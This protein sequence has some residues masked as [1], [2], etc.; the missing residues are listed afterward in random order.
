MKGRYTL[1]LLILNLAVA[2]V[3][4]YLHILKNNR[5]EE[6]AVESEIFSINLNDADYLKIE[7]RELNATRII[8]KRNGEWL[9]S[10]PMQWKANLH[11]VNRV[12]NQLRWLKPQ[13]SFS[14]EETRHHDQSLEDYGLAQPRLTVTIG[15]GTRRESLR[16]GSA[17]TVGDRIYALSPDDRQIYVLSHKIVEALLMQMDD[18]RS[19]DIL[20][21]PPTEVSALRIQNREDSN[22][23]SSTALIREGKQWNFETPIRARA[24]SELVEETLSRLSQTQA[25]RFLDVTPDAFEQYGVA[26]GKL[27]ILLE[28]NNRRETLLI[29]NK[30]EATNTTDLVEHVYARLAVS[31]RY[32]LY[33]PD[34][35][36]GFMSHKPACANAES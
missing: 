12:L 20:A 36:N 8:E 9:I 18:I 3:I 31:Q 15:I 26:N 33:R 7:G 17:T 11:A 4:V 1:L 10:S 13:G 30:V 22:R 27:S 34:N 14:W 19:H 28:G 29:G 25:S 32:S 21:I 16:I 6:S 23:T 35:W 2:G 24:S 5:L